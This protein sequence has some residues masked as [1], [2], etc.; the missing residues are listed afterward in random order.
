M[1][2]PAAGCR[3]GDWL[4]RYERGLRAKV[5]LT[6]VRSG[7]VQLRRGQVIV[8]RRYREL[9]CGLDI[10]VAT[11]ARRFSEAEPT[12]RL[13]HSHSVRTA[14][15]ETR[16]LSLMLLRLQRSN[17]SWWG[18]EV[19]VRGETRRSSCTEPT[20][21]ATQRPCLQR[22][23]SSSGRRILIAVHPPAIIFRRKLGSR[24]C[25][26][27]RCIDWS[28]RS[29][30]ARRSLED[31]AMGEPGSSSRTIRPSSPGAERDAYE[32]PSRAAPS[33]RRPCRASARQQKSGRGRGSG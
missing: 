32:S 10:S 9:R 17:G 14:T 1:V 2:D 33:R 28:A 11:I 25:K 22:G 16:Q 19:P 26:L 27:G 12:R 30:G 21:E 8:D 7:G 4:I 31:R 18:R 24:G 3:T 5:S 15:E 13:Q 6:F 23:A 29:A 20:S